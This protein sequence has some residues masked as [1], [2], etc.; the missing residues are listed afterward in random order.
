[1]GI[2]HS[3]SNG[4]IQPSLV[5]SLDPCL[6]ET[7]A[8]RYHYIG[9]CRGQQQLGAGA[10]LVLQEDPRDHLNFCHDGYRKC[11][12]RKLCG[13]YRMDGE[14]IIYQTRYNDGTNDCED[15][16]DSLIVDKPNDDGFYGK[17]G[18]G[19]ILLKEGDGFY[20]GDAPDGP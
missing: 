2:L 3:C 7:K 10:P 20:G 18:D 8:K 6:A 13:S 9:I 15:E 4:R 12:W 16:I 19:I 1:M 11:H 17:S 5:S 14:D